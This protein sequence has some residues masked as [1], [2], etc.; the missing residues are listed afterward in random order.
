MTWFQVHW[1]GCCLVVTCTVSRA[2]TILCNLVIGA[3]RIAGHVNLAAGI[4]HHAR[5]TTRPLAI[6]GITCGHIA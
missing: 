4:R 3:L 1:F 2:T 6:L 5:D